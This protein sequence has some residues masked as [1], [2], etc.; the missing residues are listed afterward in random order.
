MTLLVCLPPL[1]SALCP[2]SPEPLAA[3]C[4]EPVGAW[5]G[6]GPVCWAMGLGCAEERRLH[7]G[8]TEALP[9]LEG[10]VFM[11]GRATKV[12]PGVL[13]YDLGLWALLLLGMG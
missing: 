8:R 3:T 1:P 2:L 12:E 6:Q 11:H 5:L 9:G 4:R 10:G 7:V 13:P